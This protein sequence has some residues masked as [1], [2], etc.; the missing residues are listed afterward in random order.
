MLGNNLIMIQILFLG[1]T[2][3]LLVLQKY[4]KNWGS[5][6]FLFLLFIDL[7]VVGTNQDWNLF[8]IKPHKVS[9]IEKLVVD[10]PQKEYAILT[11]NEFPIINNKKGTNKSNFFVIFKIFQYKYN[12]NINLFK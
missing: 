2:G 4:L 6:L 8:Q 5:V 10:N 12:V 1:I 3:L 11:E 9:N 7:F